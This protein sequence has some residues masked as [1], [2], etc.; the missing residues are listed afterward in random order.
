MKCMKVRFT[1]SE[2]RESV[3]FTQMRNRTGSTMLKVPSKV[4]KLRADLG[5][6]PA[7]AA[8]IHPAD[9]W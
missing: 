1:A 5:N 9:S 4:V 6:A 2:K 3:K 8:V 7:L